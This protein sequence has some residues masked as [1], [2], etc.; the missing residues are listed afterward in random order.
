MKK[1]RKTEEEGVI[2]E[3]SIGDRRCDE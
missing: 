3:R 1:R 2:I